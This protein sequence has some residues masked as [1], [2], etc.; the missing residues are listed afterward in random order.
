[1]KNYFDLQLL[2]NWGKAHREKL[3]KENKRDHNKVDSRTRA[4]T[5]LTKYYRVSKNRYQQ[6][7][8]LQRKRWNG[9]ISGNN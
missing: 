3:I 2:S 8:K 9:M 4:F 6:P 7:T 1:M 5:L